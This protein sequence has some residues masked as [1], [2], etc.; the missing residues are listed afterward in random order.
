MAP[1]D[2][3]ADRVEGAKP[4]HA[5][6][7]LPDHLADADFHLARGLVGEG[8]GEDFR[9]PRPPE[10]EDVR[11]PRGEHAR[12]AGAGARQHQDGPVQRFHR[13]ALLGVQVGKIGR[14]A[15]AQRARGNAARNRLRA[16]R[17]GCRS[18]RC[19]WVRPCCPG[20]AATAASAILLFRPKMAFA[21]AI[22]EA[23]RALVGFSPPL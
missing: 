7:D 1:Q 17:S 13:L 10:V 14:A 5:F 22:F 6:D 21:G 18:G 4:R 15:G 11:N 16:R 23:R 8:D 9:R 12:L 3:H 19:A 20:R 2:L